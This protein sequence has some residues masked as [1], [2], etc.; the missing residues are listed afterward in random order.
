MVGEGG[1]GVRWDWQAGEH[2][3]FG[4]IL[5]VNAEN[6]LMKKSTNLNFFPFF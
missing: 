1:S 4:R 3:K 5:G 6:E 2:C